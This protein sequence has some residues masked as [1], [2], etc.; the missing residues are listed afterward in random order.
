M[1]QKKYRV[2]QWA[3]GQ[4]GR[5]AIRHFIENPNFELV[6]VYVTSDDKVGKDAGVLAGVDAVGVTATNDIEALLTTEADC[7]HYSPLKLDLET[8]CRLLGSGKNVVTPAGFWYPTE[9]YQQEVDKIEAACQQGGVSFHGAG[10]H[11][12]F[13]GD[14]LP[15]TLTRLMRRIDCIH[16]QEM[17][18]FGKRPS[19]WI[20]HLG[21]GKSEQEVRQNP[22]RSPEAIHFFAQ[23]MA[24]LVEGLG[25]KIDK[26]TSDQEFRLAPQDITYEGGVIKAGT[27][28]GQHYEWKA[29]ADGRP[30]VVFHTFWVMSDDVEPAWQCD[31]NKYRIVIDGDPGTEVILQ[32]TGEASDAGILWTT[33]AAITALPSV[34]DAPPGLL[35][36]LDLGVVK[37]QGVV[38]SC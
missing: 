23:S 25:K 4:V 11:P 14:I 17:V 37:P 34:C 5:H 7:V 26:L 24:M 13:V 8:V 20:E 18:N 30:L 32:G 10:I 33:M 15:L 6:G 27:L 38:G 1:S 19:R 35:T 29:W 31:D 16:I 3:T 36:H 12:G 21:F 22:P 28:A 9:R 2:I